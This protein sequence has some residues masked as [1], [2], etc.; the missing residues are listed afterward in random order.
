MS[1]EVLIYK[2]FQE[3]KIPLSPSMV[4]ERLNLNCPLTSIRR[5]MT[6]LT[7]DGKLTKT[8]R[9]VIGIYDKPEHLWEAVNG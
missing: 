7:T 5:A 4:L 8:N 2:H 9:Y 6:N 1:Q 3:Y